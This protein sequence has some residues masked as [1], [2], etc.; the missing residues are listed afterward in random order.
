[1]KKI[2]NN[3]K[4]NVNTT[5]VGDFR[6]CEKSTLTFDDNAT[7][8]SIK[9]TS[10]KYGAKEIKITLPNGDTVVVR[11]YAT[12]ENNGSWD[13]D[14]TVTYIDNNKSSINSTVTKKKSKNGWTDILSNNKE[15]ITIF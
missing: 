4:M 9:A 12:V 14:A 11:S 13:T 15:I 3:L 8:I 10:E 7:E 2:Y 1:M 5:S 6:V